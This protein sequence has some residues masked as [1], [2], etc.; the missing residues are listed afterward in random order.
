[1]DVAGPRAELF[2]RSGVIEFF[3]VAETEQEAWDLYREPAEYFCSRCFHVF[4]GF[5]DLVGY[6]T[7]N[8]VR[9][10]VEG[11]ADWAP[12]ES[13]A[14]VANPGRFLRYGRAEPLP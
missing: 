5:A 14:R 9:A 10:G 12:R 3:G 7:A 4:P 13:A 11:M 6:K 8:T 1:M 2:P